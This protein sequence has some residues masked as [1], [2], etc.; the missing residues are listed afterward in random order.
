VKFWVCCEVRAD[1][2]EDYRGYAHLVDWDAKAIVKT[3]EAPPVFHE[4]LTPANV[5][6]ATRG[7]RA[8]THLNGGIYAL[9]NSGAFVLDAETLVEK[10]RI[11]HAMWLGGHFLYFDEDGFWMNCNIA[12]CLV[13]ITTEGHI[14]EGIGLAG[15]PDLRAQLDFTSKRPSFRDARLLTEEDIDAEKHGFKRADQLHL[16][17]FQKEGERILLGSCTRKA[18][19][20]VWPEPHVLFRDEK[21]NQPHD[22]R[23][24]GDYLVV[25]N[26]AQR[27]L[28]VYTRKGR[29]L[30]EVPIPPYR[31]KDSGPQAFAGYMR[32][33]LVLDETHVL[34]GYAPLGVLEVDLDKREVVSRMQMHDNAWHTCHGLSA[35]KEAA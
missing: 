20:E 11:S 4:H 3:W 10:K 1:E 34:V 22:F 29:F 23:Y 24:V 21:L 2:Y 12:D 27:V 13:K 5:G 16:N 17:S 26:S 33:L 30:K 6:R 18:F 32:G 31:A 35:Y 25:C 9:A 14:Q 28:H 15:D 7:I 8:M 19:F